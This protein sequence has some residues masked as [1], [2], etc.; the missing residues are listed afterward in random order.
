MNK[1]FTFKYNI[2]KF[3]IRDFLYRIFIIFLVCYLFI[4]NNKKKVNIFK[5]IY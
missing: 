2:N 1:V 4:F 5:Y 3:L